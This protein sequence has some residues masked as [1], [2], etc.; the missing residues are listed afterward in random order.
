[1]KNPS[2][3]FCILIC[4]LLTNCTLFT[5]CAR[6]AGKNANNTVTI[7]TWNVQTFFDANVDGTEF[8]EFLDEEKWH[9]DAYCARLEKLCNVLKTFSADVLVLCEVENSAVMQD[10]INLMSFNCKWRYATFYKDEKNAFG[11]G[12][13]SSYPIKDVT[14]HQSTFIESAQIVYGAQVD[15]NGS[16]NYAPKQTAPLRPLLQVTLQHP[17]KDIVLV[18]CHWKSKLTSTVDSAILRRLQEASLAEIFARCTDTGA[19][20]N[21]SNE[22]ALENVPICIATGDFN[23]NHD[24]FLLCDNFTDD[25][26]PDETILRTLRGINCT[27]FVKSAWDYFAVEPKGSYNYRGNWETIDNIL[28]LQSKNGSTNANFTHF[29]VL[30]NDELCKADGAPFAYSVHNGKGFSDHFAISASLNID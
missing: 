28:L 27:Q 26:T 29:A 4:A 14:A 25:F 18:A 1:M 30:A 9:K 20:T 15:V 8:K 17:K 23:Q 16:V 7:T 11:C 3:I 2:I 5:S 6:T 22:E 24:E 10:I 12:V 19:Q 13:F 21:N